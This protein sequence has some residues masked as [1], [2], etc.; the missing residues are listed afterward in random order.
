MRMTRAGISLREVGLGLDEI[1]TRRTA[2]NDLL[3]EV[4]G[5]RWVEKADR[6]GHKMD[7]NQM[8]IVYGE[9]NGQAK[10]NPHRMEHGC[11]PADRVEATAVLQVYGVWAH[12]SKL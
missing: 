9:V 7:S 1:T 12:G 3:I 8:P 5:E 11:G 10:K 2:A 6:E 4:E